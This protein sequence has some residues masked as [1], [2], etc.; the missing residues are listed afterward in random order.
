[1]LSLNNAFYQLKAAL[2]PLYDA[3]EAEAVAHEFLHHITGLTR[4]E[5]LMRKQELLTP[6]QQHA[7][8]AGT[9]A[10]TT[11][12]PLQQ[13]THTAWFMR[14]Q[15]YVNEHVLIPRPETEELVQWVVDDKPVAATILDIG[16]GS[17]CIPVSLKLALPDA[18]VNAIDISDDALQV[19]MR[20]AKTHSAKVSF[21]QID[22][23]DH[24]AQQ[25]LGK[26]DIIISN[27]PYIPLSEIEKL[28]P[29][30]R[31][32]EPHTALFVPTND[33]LLFYR[34]IAIFGKTHLND[35]GSIYCELD[36]AHAAATKTLF[37]EH[38]YSN[39]VLRKDLNDNWR[40]LKANC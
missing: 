23:L 4:T 19:A 20:N 31:E 26:Y 38:G 8:D 5:R 33:A 7:Y 15:Y 24:A 11:G 16:T 22:F 6:L 40:M 39:V 29:N 17:G 37:E 3:R 21:Q 2:Q 30:V 9:A 25:G 18:T 12:K 35:G 36:A 34:E 10:L 14:R 32:H 27:P 28:H 1:M 13:V